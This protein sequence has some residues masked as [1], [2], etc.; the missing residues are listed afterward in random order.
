MGAPS[1]WISNDYSIEGPFAIMHRGFGIPILF[2]FPLNPQS[3]V[4]SHPARGQVHQ[5]VDAN[6][7]DDF[8]GPRAVLSRVVLR[9][10]FGFNPRWGGIGP[11]LTGSL[12]L[13]A[14]ETI[15]ETFNALSRALKTRAGAVQEFIMPSR[16]IYWR[17][18]IDRLDYRTESR[19][20]LLY[21]YDVSM[22]RLQDYLSPGGPSMP[23]GLVPPIVSSTLGGLFSSATSAVSGLF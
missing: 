2:L 10:T 18:W 9:G 23:P 6:F 16:L 1:S 22:Q 21:F 12:H 11:P 14:F 7:L 3:F 15:F 5:T 17:V 19:D 20:P 8:S 4:V 13:K